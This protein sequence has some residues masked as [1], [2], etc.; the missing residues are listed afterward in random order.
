MDLHWLLRTEATVEE[1]QH[2]QVL[3][4]AIY[5]N[6]KRNQLVTAFYF[7]KKLN[8]HF[9]KFVQLN[10]ISSK[11]TLPHPQPHIFKCIIPLHC[12]NFAGI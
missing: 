1:T 7:K 4:K 8:T 11:E 2:R 5:F 12:L 10:G 3:E 6:G 9:F